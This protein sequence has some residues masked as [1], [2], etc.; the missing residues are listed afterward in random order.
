MKQPVFLPN[1]DIWETK[2]QLVIV[3]EIPGAEPE[4]VDVSVDRDVLRISARSRMTSPSGYSPIHAE[5]R[6]GDYQR[7]FTLPSAIDAGKIEAT[8]K[9]GLLK[10]VL[11]KVAPP[12]ARRIAIKVE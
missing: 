1:T 6:E 2:D 4:S 5:Y 12:P 11:P 10:L 7:S 3:A 8:V 9:D